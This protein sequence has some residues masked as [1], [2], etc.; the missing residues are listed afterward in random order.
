MLRDTVES[1]GCLRNAK[2]AS[3]EWWWSKAN[4]WVRSASYLQWGMV[5]VGVA[6]H[7]NNN[8]KRNNRR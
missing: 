5:V 7:T 2:P 4:T 8:H 3:T 1:Y 6:K